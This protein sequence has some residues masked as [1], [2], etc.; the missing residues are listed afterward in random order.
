MRS[1]A[2]SYR[3]LSVSIVTVLRDFWYFLQ[4]SP[5]RLAAADRKAHLRRTLRLLLQLLL[6]LAL[7][8]AT[9]PTVASCCCS[10]RR[11]FCRSRRPC[12]FAAAVVPAP[13]LAAS[14]GTVPAPAERSR[15]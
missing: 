13:P 4:D 11:Y 3:L 2:I 10:F 14:F 1:V 7:A 8:A 9:A 5:T 12:Y 6:P 15:A